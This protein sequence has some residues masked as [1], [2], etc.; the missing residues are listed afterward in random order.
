[1]EWSNLGHILVT[2]TP[3]RTLRLLLAEDRA[4]VFESWSVVYAD[5][6]VDVSHSK[7]PC[8]PVEIRCRE[9]IH[10]IQRCHAWIQELP[11]DR[12]LMPFVTPQHEDLMKG[13]AA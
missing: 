11:G 10:V 9:E 13:F 1:M 4:H 12:M 6:P 8:G 2:R 7:S 5:L 3:M